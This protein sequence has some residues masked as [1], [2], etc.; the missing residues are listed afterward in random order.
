MRVFIS[1]MAMLALPVIAI[2]APSPEQMYRDAY[3][4]VREARQAEY[5]KDNGL[6]WQ[7]YQKACALL[8]T[9][10]KKYPG[11]NENAV[12]AQ[13]TA[14][15]GGRSR[16]A[17][18]TAED[19]SEAPSLVRRTA[20]GVGQVEEDKVSFRYQME[21]ERRK[22]NEIEDL[23]RRFARQE[24]ARKVLGMAPGQALTEEEIRTAEGGA[25]S[26]GGEGAAPAPENLD[27]DNDGLTDDE[28]VTWGTDPLNEDTDNDGL[29][30]G[31]EVHEYITDP[32]D[33]DTDGDVLLD[34]EEVNEYDTDPLDT[35]TDGGGVSD[36]DEVNDND[37][38]PLDP[39]DDETTEEE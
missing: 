30:D 15:T 24:M 1:A 18:V 20:A 17:P 39:D 16:T 11:W 9:I 36:G 21:W 27:S 38:D 26:G 5:K 34:G 29:L 28:E 23:M 31:E 22:I 2:S 19:I 8:E 3:Q 13:L 6:A 25:P 37:T 4:M 35:D 12:E 33:E 10:R 14:C 32:L 7:R